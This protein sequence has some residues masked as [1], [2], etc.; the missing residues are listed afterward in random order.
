MQLAG[1]VKREQK[2]AFEAKLAR[3]RRRMAAWRALGRAEGVEAEESGEESEGEEGG[4]VLEGDENDGEDTGSGV[5]RMRDAVVLPPI[6]E[7]KGLCTS[8]A[9]WAA[10][11]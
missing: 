1:Y 4:V 11:D 8:F 6:C 3:R 5:V 10:E 2:A 7:C 9:D